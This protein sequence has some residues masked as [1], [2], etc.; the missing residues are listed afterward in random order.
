MRPLARGRYI[1][2]PGAMRDTARTERPAGRRHDN[3]KRWN[4][5]SKGLTANSTPPAKGA[6]HRPLP[7]CESGR[8]RR[9]GSSGRTCRSPLRAAPS[10]RGRAPYRRSRARSPPASRRPVA[11][12][13][14]AGRPRQ[15]PARPSRSRTSPRVDPG[16]AS[17][18]PLPA[19]IAIVR[20]PPP[21]RRSPPSDRRRAPIATIPA[22]IVDPP[23]GRPADPVD[24][25]A[26]LDEL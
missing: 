24:V 19:D 17:P 4:L 18:K 20:A 7:A 6:A 8:L 10:P 12:C 2:N 23:P 22:G 13:A 1:S 16:V 9:L 14:S 26:S 5:I 15:P 3:A 11:W 25:K 21:R